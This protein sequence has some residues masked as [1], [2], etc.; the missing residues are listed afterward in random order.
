MCTVVHRVQNFCPFRSKI[1][2]FRDNIH[3][4]GFRI[5]THVKIAKCHSIFITW[6][7]V[8]KNYSLCSTMVANVL[9]KFG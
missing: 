8:K 6:S 3:I 9:I 1:S 2:R 5:D 4:L 7:I